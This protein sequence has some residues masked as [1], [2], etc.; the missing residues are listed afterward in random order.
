MK[1]KV[2]AAPLH[3]LPADLRA[4]IH[5]EAAIKAAWDDTSQVASCFL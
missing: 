3:K 4:A 2:V 5:S 1:K